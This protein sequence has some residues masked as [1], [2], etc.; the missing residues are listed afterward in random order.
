MN[1]ITL[2]EQAGCEMRAPEIRFDAMVAADRRVIAV[3]IRE[4]LWPVA[5]GLHPRLGCEMCAPRSD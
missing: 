5:T 4:L 3:T 1:L 2:L